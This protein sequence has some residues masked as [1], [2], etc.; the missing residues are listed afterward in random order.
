MKTD[1]I[2]AFAKENNIIYIET[3]AKTGKNVHDALAFLGQKMLTFR[4]QHQLEDKMQQLKRPIY[5]R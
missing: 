4:Q 3:S 5:N 2:K 1:D